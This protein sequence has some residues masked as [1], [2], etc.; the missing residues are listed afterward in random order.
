MT[1]SPPKSIKVISWNLWHR[2]RAL[3]DD[4]TALI[5]A[6]QPDLL[7]IQEAKEMLE[8]LSERVG[9]EVHWQRMQ[10]RVYGLAAW[11]PH[12]LEALQSIPLP[13]SPFPLRVPPRVAQV[14]KLNG[15][16]FANVHLSHGQVLNRRQL[17]T[18]ANAT[19]GAT[20]IIGDCNAVGHIWLKG[21]DEV[22]PMERTHKLRTRLDRCMVRDL[23]CQNARVL[24]RG[25]SDHHPIEVLLQSGS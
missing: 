9:G 4:L 18:V 19:S 5:E 10:R 6:E 17:L 7:F 12:G 14:V 11:S 20:A 16:T 21:F 23:T 13:V 8:G 1:R 3:L 24:D 22:G 2:G 15:I 25:P